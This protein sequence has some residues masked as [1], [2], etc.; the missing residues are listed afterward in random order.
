MDL[1]YAPNG[2]IIVLWSEGIVVRYS[3][4]SLELTAQIRLREWKL[5]HSYGYG[6]SYQYAN[7][8]LSSKGNWIAS[9]GMSGER[10]VTTTLYVWRVSQADPAPALLEPYYAETSDITGID[11][12]FSKNEKYLACRMYGGF[13]VWQLD[14]LNPLKP[15]NDFYRP[16]VRTV[17]NTEPNDVSRDIEL[18]SK[19]GEPDSVSQNDGHQG[20][21]F[22]RDNRVLFWQS[23]RSIITCYLDPNPDLS[24]LVLLNLQSLTTIPITPDG[25]TA[26]AAQPVKDIKFTSDGNYL[27]ILD[28]T[29]RL[30]VW[31]L[32]DFSGVPETWDLV[33]TGDDPAVCSYHRVADLGTNQFAVYGNPRANERGEM[34]VIVFNRRKGFLQA[35]SFNL[36]LKDAGGFLEGIVMTNRSVRVIREDGSLLTGQISRN[37]IISKRC[38]KFVKFPRT[39]WEEKNYFGEFDDKG[40]VYVLAERKNEHPYLSSDQTHRTHIQWQTTVSP[41]GK[42]K[43]TILTERS[44]VAVLTV[45]QDG[46]KSACGHKNGMISITQFTARAQAISFEL[47]SGQTSISA[48]TISCDGNFLA[49]GGEDKSIKIWDLTRPKQSPILLM[50]GGDLITKLAFSSDNRFLVSVDKQGMV[51]LWILRLDDL[52]QSLKKLVSRTISKAEWSEFV[53]EDIL[54][55][56]PI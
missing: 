54:Y 38:R 11:I 9:C 3:L 53:G 50:S 33:K 36:R 14:L 18:F 22:S 44:R 45:A 47:I 25:R 37:R 6:H 52:A 21:F 23:R 16:V 43:E 48:L 2:D 4:P 20:I 19:N 15:E 13:R 24:S 55:E 10:P 35:A 8:V 49:S 46:S 40:K 7:A 1:I 41:K 17:Y 30:H 27:L 39:S 29:H 34:P 26:T 42:I 31:R 56:P 28:V 32:N 12:V 51:R 5:I